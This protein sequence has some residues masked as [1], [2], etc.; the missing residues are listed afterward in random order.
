[1]IIVIARINKYKVFTMWSVHRKSSG[2][3]IY[4]YYKVIIIQFLSLNFLSIFELFQET[5]ILLTPYFSCS[6]IHFV[7]C[8]YSRFVVYYLI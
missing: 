1:M 6:K 7:H 4:N 3:V 2:N 5:A 8:G